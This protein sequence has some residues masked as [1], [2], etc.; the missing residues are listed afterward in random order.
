M[1]TKV[2]LAEAAL[3]VE[4]TTSNGGRYH[5]GRRATFGAIESLSRLF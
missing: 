3:R 4:T 2:G 5:R 1:A